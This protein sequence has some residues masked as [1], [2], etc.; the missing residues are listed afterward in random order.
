VLIGG[1]VI[2]GM[3]SKRVVLR[4]IGASLA[5][6]PINLSNV[7]AN[8]TIDIFDKNGKISTDDNWA[9]SQKDDLIAAGY[10]PT[11]GF[12]SAVLMVLNPGAYTAIVR[13]NS[14]TTGVALVELFDLTPITNSTVTSSS[15]ANISTRGFVQNGD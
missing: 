6:P 15:V 13:G 3:E 8:P 7:L 14:N 2:T 4:A 10:A 5:N 9:D 12:E 1:F 11:D